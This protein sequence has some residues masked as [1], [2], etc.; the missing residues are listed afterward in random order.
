MAHHLSS[1]V[2]PASISTTFNGRSVQSTLWRGTL[3]VAGMRT[4]DRNSS[5][6]LHVTAVETDGERYV[7]HTHTHTLVSARSFPERVALLAGWIFG[8]TTSSYTLN[9]IY[10]S[11]ENSWRGS[12]RT[13]PQR[14]PSCPPTS[15]TQTTTRLIKAISAHCL[16]SYTKPKL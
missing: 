10:P 9:I 8:L 15:R 14:A 2:N 11:S 7:T 4:S 5:Q 1:A 3:A 6:Q 13:T 12:A 16:G